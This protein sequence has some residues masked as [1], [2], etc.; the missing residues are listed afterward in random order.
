F[1]GRRGLLRK[2]Y[3]DNTTNSVGAARTLDRKATFHGNTADMETIAAE[4][5]M[6]PN[7]GEVLTPGHF[8]IGPT[9]VGAVVL[10]GED[11]AP[12]Q[13]WMLGVVTEA[14][15]GGNGR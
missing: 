3:C 15:A 12:S 2:L 14:I 5:G 8:L 9:E 1:I 7:D 6:N 4:G 10:V 13:Q 11:N